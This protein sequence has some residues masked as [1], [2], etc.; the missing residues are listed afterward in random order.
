MERT[1]IE[2]FY[3]SS[4]R[5][6]TLT[7]SVFYRYLYSKI[8]WNNRLICI[9]GGRGVGKSTL[10]LQHIKETFSDYNKALYLSLDNIKINENV[11]LDIVEYHYTHGGTHIFFDEVHKFKHWQ[12]LIKTLY[13]DYPTL[14]IVYTGSSM[15]QIDAKEG[16]LSR[17]Q[18]VYE[19]KGMSFREF[20]E[21][22]SQIK[23]NS[24]EL[25][26]ILNS[27]INIASAIVSKV[28]P[29]P[30]FEKYLKMGYYPFY[31]EE[32]DGYDQRIQEVVRQVLE[33]DLPAVEP[34]GFDT[35]LKL[36]QMLTILSE[37]V[38]ITPNMK[39]LYA[40]L[41]TNREQGLKM[42]NL[43]ER[44]G[45]LSLLSDKAKTLKKMTK[46][47]KFYLE[48]TNLMYAISNRID[49]GTARE[50]FFYNQLIESHSVT[51]PILGDFLVNGKYLFEVGG[52]GKKFS[53]I[54]D[55]PDSFVAADSI[56]IGHG[57]KIPL[58][59]FG[60]LY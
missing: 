18:R 9:K 5:K 57:N 55:I 31:K 41:E 7:T 42:L 15:L 14:N 22:E 17:R 36:K 29:L 51:V 16:D 20:L 37:C 33:S 38:P 43:L 58:W 35:I 23:L 56:E 28:Q 54:K 21:F 34:I 8:N 46:P 27:H 49:V 10:I 39:E 45:L 25:N 30:L 60:M 59:L 2:Y 3:N 44:A 11:V 48:N 1:D 32:G 19:L 26:N 12:T 6:V 13:D 50:T 53:Q 4:I 52:K 24:L 47:S 40:S